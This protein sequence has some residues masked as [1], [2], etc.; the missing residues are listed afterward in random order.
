MTRY[1]PALVV[2]LTCLAGSAA[3]CSLCGTSISKATLAEEMDLAAVVVYG[4]I[5]NPQL[6]A[7]GTGTVDLHVDNVVK[8]DGGLGALRE[9]T[10]DRYV[11]V[12][13]PKRPPKYLVFLDKARGKFI[14]ST[15]FATKTPAVLEYLEGGIAARKEGR[16]A[17]LRFYA[18]Y[19]NHEEPL[20]ATDAFLEFAKSKDADIGNAGRALDPA[21]IRG[22][23]SK[24]DLDPDRLSMF[25]FLL[26]CCGKAE[27]TQ[28]LTKIASRLEGERFRA[29][30]GILA[31]CVLLKPREG[32][33]TVHGILSD[34]SK[35]FQTRLAC[36]RALRFLHGWK[37][38]EFHADI[39]RTFDLII[40]DGELC[41]LGV[42]DLRRWQEW[43]L[44]KTIAEQ[45]DQPSHKAPIIRNGIIRYA[46]TC[47]LPEAREL[48]ERARKADPESVRDQE[49]LLADLLQVN[50]K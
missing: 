15:G 38:G 34:S 40:R 26:G 29:M 10:L 6:G 31:G 2:W 4:P 28:L 49:E 36:W 8:D 45:F 17:A 32:W 25:A 37:D 3:A 48:V 30:D 46:L 9:L 18:R 16:V 11:P 24:R 22:M 39:L 21:F 23:L 35:P 27:D 50:R 13:D 44:T 20:I 47:P 43:G 14:P 33:Q 42:E 19:L 1:L 12:Q 41:D 7:M 5:S